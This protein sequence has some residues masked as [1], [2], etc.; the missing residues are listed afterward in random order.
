MEEQEILKHH[1]RASAAKRRTKTFAVYR[2]HLYQN[3]I[4]DAANS[5]GGH[6]NNVNEASSRMGGD[7]LV[8][9]MWWDACPGLP[10]RHPLQD[11]FP[12]N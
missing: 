1:W 11:V 5:F 10:F 3:L 2:A 8:T 6:E 12:P 9:R 7:D 4:L